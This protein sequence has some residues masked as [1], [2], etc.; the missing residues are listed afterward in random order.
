[1]KKYK[2]FSIYFNVFIDEARCLRKIRFPS[3]CVPFQMPS[4]IHSTDVSTAELWFHKEADI[5]DS[6][7]QTFVV[8]EVAHWDTNKSFQKTKP[9]AIQE[10]SLTGI[11]ENKQLMQ[12]IRL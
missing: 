7:N 2:T 9:I 8:S 3:V 5:L 6:H 11:N 10:T 12:N 4:D 1:M